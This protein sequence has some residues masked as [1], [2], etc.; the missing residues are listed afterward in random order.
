[1]SAFPTQFHRPNNGER[2]VPLEQLDNIATLSGYGPAYGNLRFDNIV[3]APKA[4]TK[5]IP[6][7]R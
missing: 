5:K 6:P 3:A 7:H 2:D 1:M 4:Q